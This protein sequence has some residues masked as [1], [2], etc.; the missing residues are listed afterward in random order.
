[1]SFFLLLRGTRQGLRKLTTEHIDAQ[2]QSLTIQ[3]NGKGYS[4][5]SPASYRNKRFWVL[6]YNPR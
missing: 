6:L 3:K 5:P 1:M 2:D 4:P